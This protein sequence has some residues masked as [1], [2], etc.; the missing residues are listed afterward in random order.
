MFFPRAVQAQEDMR[1][2]VVCFANVQEGRDPKL[3]REIASAAT[4]V[5][6]ASLVR[7]FSDRTFFLGLLSSDLLN[8]INLGNRLVNSLVNTRLDNG[9]S[10]VLNLLNG[11]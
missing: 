7:M 11:I 4:S 2:A 6:G 1:R 8:P 10:L 3:L 5:P 9:F